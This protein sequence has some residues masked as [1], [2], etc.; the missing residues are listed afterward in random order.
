MMPRHVVLTLI[1]VALSTAACS[2]RQ[3]PPPPSAAAPDTAGQG[4]RA[5]DAARERARQDSIARANAE[6][7]RLGRDAVERDARVRAILEEMVFFEYDQ[8]ALRSDSQQALA[9]KVA[10]LRANPGLALTIAGHADER[11][12][13]EYNQALGMRRASSVRDYMA[14]FGIDPSRLEIT[15]YG[16]DRPLDAGS[17]EAAWARN[18]RAE[19]TILRGGTNLIE[20]GF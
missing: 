14:G 9:R 18:R 7:D 1:L 16:E 4:Q 2:R 17:N 8:S 15:S 6:R 12:S 3:P 5:L 20:P 19:F 10:V 11:G 13:V